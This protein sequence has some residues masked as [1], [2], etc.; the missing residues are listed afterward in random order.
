MTKRFKTLKNYKGIRKDNFTGRF[1]ARKYINGKEYSETFSKISDAL[2]WRNTFHP[3][4]KKKEEN[5]LNTRLNGIEETY[6]MASVWQLYQEQHLPSI[7]RQSQVDIKRRANNIIPD[8][9]NK[10]MVDIDAALIDE[11]VRKKVELEKLKVDRKRQSFDKELKTLKAIFNWYI[12]NYDAMFRMPIL[13]RHFVLGIVQIKVKTKNPKMSPSEVK[14]F[15]NSFE[16]Q[17]WKDFALIHFFMAGRVQE[18]AGLQVKNIDLKNRILTVCDVAVWGHDKNFHYL[19]E[20]PK[21]G[22]ERL[23]HLNDTMVEIL[24]RR[25]VEPRSRQCDYFRESNGERLNFVFQIDGQPVKYRQVQ[26]NYN[27]ALKRAGLFPTY[28]ATHILRKAMAN[29]VRQKLGLEA[30]QAVGGWKSREVVERVY[31][32]SA[33]TELNRSAVNLVEELLVE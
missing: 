16:D 19:K 18:P 30:A 25:I 5:V 27:K 21:N 2:N 23:V 6:S 3:S 31:T 28:R 17:F 14:N 12:E 8:L 9:L 4:L 29:I 10:R 24:R 32:D 7:T 15:F 13:K 22:H 20:T 1:Q 11:V 33:P 26:Y